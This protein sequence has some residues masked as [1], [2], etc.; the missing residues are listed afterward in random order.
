MLHQDRGVNL[1]RNGKQQA[2]EPCREL[3]IACDH[4]RPHCKRCVGKQAEG[5]CVYHPAPMT[6]KRPAPAGSRPPMPRIV[7]KVTSHVARPAQPPSV[8]VPILPNPG[9]NGTSSSSR[10][11]SLETGT[12]I[13]TPENTNQHGRAAETEDSRARTARYYGPTSFSSVFTEN[14]LLEGIDHRKHFL[15]PRPGQPLLHAD[16]S[17]TLSVQKDQIITALSNIP[18][19]DICETFVSGK[20]ESHRHITLNAVLIRHAVAGLWST[21]GGRLSFP[22]TA[23]KL[24]PIAETLLKNETPLQPAPDDGMEWL[25]AYTGSNLRVEMLGLLFCFFGMEY[26]S[27]LDEDYR[28]SVPENQGLDRKQLSWRMKECA[29][30]CLK[31]V[32]NPPV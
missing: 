29:D 26:Q 18:S 3:K 19:Q 16:M 15:P 31:M 9:S 14:G 10:P 20:S 30:I 27:L 4:A 12:V 13:R 23:E 6:K 8:P 7:S 1:R 32:R 17:S 28:L 24:N 21:F 11:S 2:C 5:S 25:R 22:R